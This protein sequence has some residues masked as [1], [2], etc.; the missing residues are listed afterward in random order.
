MIINKSLMKIGRKMD[1]DLVEESNVYSILMELFT[2]SK[3]HLQFIIRIA[4]DQPD[5]S[6]VLPPIMNAR[7]AVNAQ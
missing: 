4:Q 1:I 5:K 2:L 7:D 6:K 3:S